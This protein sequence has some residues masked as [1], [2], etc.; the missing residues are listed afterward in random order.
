MAQLVM[1]AI[2]LARDDPTG[3][4]ALSEFL[5]SSRALS[6]RGGPLPVLLE[7]YTAGNCAASATCRKML[8]VRDRGIGE[9][10]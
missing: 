6:V 9:K 1:V 8:T 7:D 3:K 10:K 2:G 5:G 4:T